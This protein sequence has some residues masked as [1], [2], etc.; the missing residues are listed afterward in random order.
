MISAVIDDD[1]EDD[2]N[3]KPVPE[4]DSLESFQRGLLVSTVVVNLLR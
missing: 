2:V 4:Q 3:A 1:D